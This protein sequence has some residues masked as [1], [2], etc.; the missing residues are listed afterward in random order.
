MYVGSWI[1]TH[2]QRL[3][4]RILKWSISIGHSNGTYILASA[5]QQYSVLTV[6]NVFFAGSVVPVHYDWERPIAEHR[7]TGKIWNI[8][9]DFDWVVAIFPQ[10][11]QQISDW[12]KIPHPEVGLLDIGSAGFRGFR[13]S[14]GT[15]G[16]LFNVKYISG[17]H[18]AAFEPAKVNRVDA[19]ADFVTAHGEKNLEILK[20]TDVPSKWLEYASNVSGS[21]GPWA[22]A[23]LRWWE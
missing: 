7:I 23:L 17:D 18:G 15:E 4:I 19:I 5:L 10:L 16:I 13:T 9:A 14:V 21:F 20:D 12:L 11:F 6:R 1:N 2:K 8:C 3:Y 22:L